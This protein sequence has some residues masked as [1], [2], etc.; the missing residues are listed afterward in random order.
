MPAAGTGVCEALRCV[1]LKGRYAPLGQPVALLH[2]KE[3][4]VLL[5]SDLLGLPDCA[6]TG[7]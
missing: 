5:C 7:R 6:F 2:Y 1:S 3:G 4:F